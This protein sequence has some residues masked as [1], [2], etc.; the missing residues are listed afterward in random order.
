MTEM[1]H[2]HDQAD[3]AE[4]AN[5]DALR[6]AAHVIQELQARVEKLQKAAPEPIAIVSTACRFPG[7]C[8]T[9]RAF[10]ELLAA[11]KDTVRDVPAERWDAER[12]YDPER[13]KRWSAYTK[14]GSFLD[15][16]VSAFDA[17]AFGV[18]PREAGSIDPQQRILLEVAWEAIENAGISVQ[19][20]SGS[21]T[22]VYMGVLSVD[23]GRI[24]LE[25]L[26]PEDLPYSGT[27]MEFSFPA[28]RISYHLGLRGPSMVVASACSS[29]LVCLHQAAAALRNRECDL[30]LAGGVN[31]MLSP[32]PYI[33]LSKLGAIAPDGR[34]KTFDDS[35]DGYGRGEGLG[36]IVLKRLSDAVRDG[37]PVLALVAG[38]AVNHDGSA[39]GISV[40]NGAAQQEVIQQ[41]L[42]SA[43][44]SPDHID[45]VEAHGTGTSLGDPIELDALHA[46]F[47]PGRDPRRPLLVGSVKSNIGHLEGAAGV[48]SIIKVVEALRHR[49]IPRHI[50]MRTPS[51]HVDWQRGSLRVVTEETPWSDPPARRFAG[52]SAFGLSGINAHIVLAAPDDAV[53]Q[54]Q[55]LSGAPAPPSP[56][57]HA[58]EEGPQIVALSAKTAPALAA[59]VQSYRTALGPDGTLHEASLRDLAYTSQIGRA[60]LAHR[61]ALTVTSSSDLRAQ[62]DRLSDPEALR[63]AQRTT[64]PQRPKIAFLCS[65]QGSQYAHMGRELYEQEP[66]FRSALDH[67]AQIL[68]P[69]L[70]RPLLDV[71][72]DARPDAAGDADDPSAPLHPIHDTRYTQPA[73]VALEI[74]LAALW[75]ERGVEPDRLLGHSVGELTAA[76]LA[77]VFD[78]EGVLALIAARARLMAALP[79]TGQMWTVFAERAQVERAIALAAAGAQVAIAATNGPANVVISGPADG[80]A[81][82]IAHL[83]AI[84]V[85]VQRL[86]VSHAF[87]SALMEPMLEDFAR[88]ARTVRYAPPQLPL[89][90]NLT[91]KLAGP[92]VATAAYWVDHVRREVR[93]EAGM[94]TLEQLDTAIYLELGPRPALLGLGQGALPASRA[95]WIP[96]LRKGRD[97]SRQMLEAL[98]ELHGAGVDVRW[99]AL[100]RDPRPQVL[101]LPNYPFQRAKY[102]IRTLENWGEESG[103]IKLAHALL[104][105][106]VASPAKQVQY[107]NALDASRPAF[108]AH[109]LVYGAVVL[110]GAC[111]LE[112]ALAGGQRALG[113][114]DVQVSD[115]TFHQPLELGTTPTRVATVFTPAEGRSYTFE[116]ASLDPETSLDQPSWVCHASGRVHLGERAPREAHLAPRDP[117]AA[118]DTKVDRAAL[119]ARCPRTQDV[120]RFYE[121]LQRTGITYGAAF[122]GIHE[123]YAGEGE[124]L[125]RIVCDPSLAKEAES[126]RLHPALLD[127]CFQSLGAGFDGQAPSDD[128]YLPVGAGALRF[129]RSPGREFW[130][131]ARTTGDLGGELSADLALFAPDGEPIAELTS[132]R[133]KPVSRERIVRSKQRALRKWLY[134]VAWRP[135]RAVDMANDR[136]RNRGV[137]LFAEAT[138]LGGE[139]REALVAQSAQPYMV[140]AGPAFQR[141]DARTFQIHP[142]RPHDYRAVLDTLE[143]EGLTIDAVVHLGSLRRAARESDLPAAAHAHASELLHLTQA[144]VARGG[145]NAPRLW[146]VTQGAL[147]SAGGGDALELA[148]AVAWGLGKVILLEHPELQLKYIDLPA[149]DTDQLAMR[150][151]AE[152][153]A[154][155]AETYVALRKDGRRVPRL[156]R[157]PALAASGD[158]L[159]FRAD[160]TY[161]ITGGA[162]AL[163]ALTARFLGERGAGCLALVSRRG[164]SALPPD[165]RAELEATGAKVIVLEGDIGNEADVVRMLGTIAAELP[166]LR[167]I[168]HAAGVLDDGV[169]LQ[170]TPERFAKVMGPKIDGAMH[171]HRHTRDLPLD[172]FVLYAS[173]ASVMGRPGQSN[174][175]AA[176]LFLDELA[177]L[178]RAQG[179]PALS[180]DWGAWRWVGLAAE[181]TAGEDMTSK[182]MAAGIDAIEPEQGLAILEMLMRSH[183]AQAAVMPLDWSKLGPL[184]SMPMFSELRAGAE[185]SDPSGPP[186]VRTLLE[187]PPRERRA[188]LSRHIELLIMKTLGIQADHLPSPAQGFSELGMDSLMAVE[189]RNR[190]QKSFERVFPGT[191]AFDHPNLEALTA[192]VASEVLPVEEAPA[193]SAPESPV[194]AD[195]AAMLDDILLREDAELRF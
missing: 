53:A 71:L 132:F 103:K 130:V 56:A 104:G 162:G 87:H 38:S 25:S 134:D 175:V 5:L 180:I 99:K 67:C 185:E 60:H 124:T 172:H 82:V 95:V 108:V 153:T 55:A 96:S 194:D 80:V 11:G 160:A 12:L 127:A 145:K 164:A 186:F 46:I 27:G 50:G 89:V 79:R 57:T 13:R 2:D 20:L 6:R 166:P 138:G 169:I 179:L 135:S 188:Q 23:Y 117:A 17:E 34:C 39:G 139:L 142:A 84:P 37:N 128:A 152:L 140:V 109:H 119:Q 170:Q 29:S 146:V 187:A 192:F 182:D 69:H 98:A 157:A 133:F 83:R 9:P 151:L 31:L 48:A 120:A 150:L 100:H 193:G 65:G 1:N 171:L 113:T 44:L 24:P 59:L 16:D 183:P 154:D 131:H 118:R 163:G 107:H 123:V 101:V 58:N 74:A 61:V 36:V 90:S 159:R 195:V 191:V 126:L 121:D 91:G 137:L 93:F 110:P 73:L 7:G 8:N 190:L 148:G 184:A 76:H 143:R 40:P 22:G 161:L 28:G 35:A 165:V 129:F 42:A 136:F 189:L 177:H 158:P 77:G 181:R 15:E 19:S 149:R 30:A 41:A 122:R 43:G 26:H 75:R 32:E 155:D 174:Y 147:A 106:R 141:L 116:I 66:A 85:R 144:L 47:G 3:N 14:V 49:R 21:R 176:N 72:F 178:R 114:H 168:L 52:I 70:E 68:A 54:A 45:Y 18:S 78:R 125:A 62:L 64:P 105:E 88:V 81:R 94:H 92:E 156:Q 111:Y 10:W 33:V 167:G 51:S 115:V 97:A 63:S 86:T 4:R 173:A 112:M 102:W